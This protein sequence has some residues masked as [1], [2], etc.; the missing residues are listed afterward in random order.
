MSNAVLVGHLA[1]CF[2]SF[3]VYANKED[4]CN[5]NVFISSFR[6]FDEVQLHTICDLNFRYHE[7]ITN[8]P[9]ILKLPVIS[10]LSCS[11]HC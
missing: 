2:I 6:V 4:L 10:G 11:K 5:Q 7:S 9:E 3:L 1:V 8:C